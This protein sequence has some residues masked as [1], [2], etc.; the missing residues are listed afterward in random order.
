M[1]FPG[2]FGR[3]PHDPERVAKCMQASDILNLSM[4]PSRPAA[5]DWSMRDGVGIE[6]PMFRND[7]LGTC[8]IA[9]LIDKF[10]T[11]AFQTGTPF[12]PTDADA[13]LGYE[14]FG[15]YVEGDAS[16][17]N[18][19]VML[20]VIKRL[21]KGET[22]A[23]KTVKVF[24]AVNPRNLELM[25]AA[26]EFFGGLWTGWDLPTA[27]SGADI[28]GT[29]P[30]GSTSG[31]WAPASAGRHATHVPLW[32]PQ[33]IGMETWTQHKP[34]TLAAVPTYCSEAY[35][36]L[37]SMWIEKLKAKCPAGLDLQ[38]LLD[39]LPMVRA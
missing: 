20:D 19:C 38:R 26:C 17:D 28:W 30:D 5:R 2:K 33:L 11:S 37:D 36:L 22:L 15:G 14:R 6:Y 8:A 9:S 34:A 24:V 27:W 18:G 39:V 10:I 23:G 35:A 7:E 3:L 1:G 32:S 25:A 12:L 13:T 31:K 29:A 16:T 4:L 21:A